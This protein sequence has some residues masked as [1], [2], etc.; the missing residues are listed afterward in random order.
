M[1]PSAQPVERT[2]HLHK[3]VVERLAA[4]APALRHAARWQWRVP[5]AIVVCLGPL[6]SWRRGWHR[7]IPPAS[8][9]WRACVRRCLWTE[10]TGVC[11]WH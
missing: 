10:P 7:S 5:P 9:F 11:P 2:L 6:R 3:P 1:P 8:N 4:Q